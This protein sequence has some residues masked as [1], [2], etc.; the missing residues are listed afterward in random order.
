VRLEN[1]SVSWSVDEVLSLWY[2]T[3]RQVTVSHSIVSEAL[4][5]AGH[6]K[7]PHSMGLLV[8]TNVQGAEI[9]GN[10]LASNMF[11]NPVAGKGAS[12]L[13]ANNYIVNPG[14]NAIHFYAVGSTAPTRASVINNVIEAG[15]DTKPNL[16]GVLAPMGKNGRPSNDQIYVAGNQ[17]ALGPRARAVVNGDGLNLADKGP[18]RGETWKLLP[19]R[20]VKKDVLTYAGTRPADRDPTDR[21]LL[22]EIAA[23]TERIVSAPPEADMVPPEPTHRVAA[24]PAD[25]RGLRSWLCREH[26]A[27]GGAPSAD[28]S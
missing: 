18:V 21:R 1:V 5:N 27:V 15:P 26:L 3:T 9:T 11:R 13:F 4:L 12:A 19:A 6:P 22:D 20:T 17:Q 24:A 16:I 28:C 25:L 8:G 14:Q 10:L 2:P 7:G 23:G